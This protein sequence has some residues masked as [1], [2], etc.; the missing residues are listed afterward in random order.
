M[1]VM[2][3]TKEAGSKEVEKYSS[4]RESVLFG[5]VDDASRCSSPV[6]IAMSKITSRSIA[7]VQHAES[8]SAPACGQRPE[9]DWML[10]F[11]MYD[12]EVSNRRIVRRR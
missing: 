2:S 1:T 12:I 11:R 9:I 3:R 6:Q 10:M 7:E 8:G 5:A 4:C